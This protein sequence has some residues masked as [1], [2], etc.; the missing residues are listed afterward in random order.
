MSMRALGGEE[1]RPEQGTLSRPLEPLSIWPVPSS[2]GRRETSRRR[3]SMGSRYSHSFGTE[4]HWEY[5]QSIPDLWVTQVLG[6]R[7]RPNAYSSEFSIEGLLTGPMQTLQDRVETRDVR[8]LPATDFTRVPDLRG[9]HGSYR[10]SELDPPFPQ[11]SVPSVRLTGPIQFISKL[12]EIWKLESSDAAPLL[13]FERS[14][15]PYVNDLLNGRVALAGRDVKDRIAYL[16]HIR[17]TLSALFRSEEVENEWLREPQAML[18]D[19]VPMSILLEG[20]ME[21]LLL[22]R[23][24]VDAVSGQ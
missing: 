20:S 23:E 2:V 3:P 18:N 14:D 10:T 17:S 8:V 19:Q 21:N 9:L 13:G 5:L 24:Y 15:W 12:L 6:R 11:P 16:F 4:I 7:L 1:H 22:V